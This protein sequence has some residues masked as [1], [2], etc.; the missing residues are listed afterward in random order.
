MTTVTQQQALKRWDTISDTL[1][2]ALVSEQN[3][4]ILNKI[5][6]TEHISEEK[7]LIISQVAG[8][9][10]MGFLHPEDVAQELKE[11]MQIDGRVAQNI[12]QTLNTK[13]FTPLRSE[14]DKVYLPVGKEDEREPS[15]ESSKG[16]A[17][18]ESVKA[19]PAPKPISTKETEPKLPSMPWNRDSVKMTPAPEAPRA[20]KPPQAPQ[21]SN[22]GP[23]MIEEINEPK[24]PNLG[25]TRFSARE[26]PKPQ[27]T[28]PPASLTSRPVEALEK[29]KP[30]GS[31]SSNQK[32]ADFSGIIDEIKKLEESGEELVDVLRKREDEQER[33]GN[34]SALPA[35]KTSP[36]GKQAPSL[37]KQESRWQEPGSKTGGPVILQETQGM[38]P[39]SPSRDF[40]LEASPQQIPAD[41]KPEE[42][43]QIAKIEVGGSQK[44]NSSGPARTE[45]IRPPKTIH[46]SSSQT[47]IARPKEDQNLFLQSQ[48]KP[49][50]LGKKVNFHSD[51]SDLPKPPGVFELPKKDQGKSVKKINYGVQDSSIQNFARTSSNPEEKTGKGW[52]KSLFGGKKN[53]KDLFASPPTPPLPHPPHPEFNKPAQISK[54][55][56]DALSK[57][58]SNTPSQGKE[59][60]DLETLSKIS[61]EGF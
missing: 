44:A 32:E 56:L 27:T 31:L 1:R 43:R 36:E 38:K 12:A 53:D 9:V 55:S 49:S 19:V 13:V 48:T 17:P 15:F 23:M 4:A 60:I 41:G 51:S 29:K 16:G 50:G 22:K 57:K 8:Y 3:V 30:A 42:T 28:T 35:H 37:P 24:L 33:K 52:F 2:E 40:H 10:L 58:P 21:A 61:D 46:Y 20:P 11:R 18:N 59:M 7:V 5:A 54:N 26:I 14:I 6:E 39:I 34:L 25:T 45:I 47:P